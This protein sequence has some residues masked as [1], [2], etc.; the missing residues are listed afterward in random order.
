MQIERGI[1]VVRSGDGRLYGLDAATGAR[2]WVYQ[3][4]LPALTIR[5]HAGVVI[6]RDAVFAGFPG[7]R[8]VAV[9]YSVDHLH[10]LRDAL[11]ESPM[12]SIF[13]A[14]NGE[15]S[16][17]RHFHP[18]E[19]RD[20]SG[21]AQFPSVS[22]IR[23]FRSSAFGELADADL[24]SLLPGVSAPFNATYRHRVFVAHKLSD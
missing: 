8:L 21:N 1:V 19:Q 5:T 7:G 6:Y 14:E 17:R 3:R 24:A 12:E 4:T 9:T 16:L 22:S 11:G 2:K 20:F 15:V 18:A 10:E 13:S 23:S